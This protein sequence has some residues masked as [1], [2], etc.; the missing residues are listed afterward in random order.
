MQT[1]QM[2]AYKKKQAK[3]GEAKAGDKDIDLLGVQQF[4][5]NSVHFKPMEEFLW[6][7]AV[8]RG[9]MENGQRYGFRVLPLALS[10]SAET[11]GETFNFVGGFMGELYDEEEEKPKLTC[12]WTTS[13][14][15]GQVI[16]MI[17]F[18]AM[19]EK[20]IAAGE[21]PGCYFIVKPNGE[22]LENEHPGA[23]GHQL[24]WTEKQMPEKRLSRDTLSILGTPEQ[25][26]AR[27][28][29]G[30]EPG[31]ETEDGEEVVPEPCTNEHEHE[32][33]HRDEH[34]HEHEEGE[35]DAGARQR[36]DTDIDPARLIFPRVVLNDP[37]ELERSK[38]AVREEDNRGTELA[39]LLAGEAY[40][41]PEDKIPWVE[42][43]KIIP[44]SQAPATGYEVRI[45]GEAAAKISYDYA[46]S[47]DQAPAFPLVGWA[48]SHVFE[49]MAAEAVRKRAA[50]QE[51]R[52]DLDQQDQKKG[53]EQEVK[54]GLMLSTTDCLTQQIDWPRQHQV[55]LLLSLNRDCEV[56]AAWY[57]WCCGQV[58]ELQGIY[59]NS[60]G[61]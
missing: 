19:M 55:A 60:N 50:E 46:S 24:L 3:K 9:L 34:E 12:R 4:P 51:E 8:R 2:V 32:H 5:L 35:Q 45:P 17:F 7:E 53:E 16:N 23:N 41:D 6:Y 54:S 33:E 30:A 14:V 58:V 37:G 39:F 31:D 47:C 22:K 27:E 40:L 48:H 28:A 44:V 43:D 59:T 1:V 42:V 26:F 20:K 29:E 57:G 36:A 15:F 49:Y 18:R 52:E 25:L 11:G 56:D 13:E 61:A 38:E 21:T 10:S